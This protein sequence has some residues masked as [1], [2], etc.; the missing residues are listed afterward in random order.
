AAVVASAIFLRSTDEAGVIVAP[1]TLAL[2]DPATNRIAGTTPDGIRPGPVA[3]GRGSFWVGNLED[4]TVTRVDPATNAVV[5]TIALGAAP[6]PVATG[7]GAV[8]AVNGRLAAVDVREPGHARRSGDRRTQLLAPDRGR[9]RTDRGRVRRGLG[10]GGEHR[11]R[12]DLAHR[13]GD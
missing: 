2:V 6:D 12:D 10:L 7:A 5:R 11:R 8:W 4:E 1:N 3:Y 9:R 13:P